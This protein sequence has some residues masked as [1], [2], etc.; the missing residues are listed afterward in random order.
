MIY[1]LLAMVIIEI[2]VI[3]VNVI[4][5]TKNKITLF[6]IQDLGIAFIVPKSVHNVNMGLVA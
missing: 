6:M 2:K 5:D 1:A 4:Q 3:F